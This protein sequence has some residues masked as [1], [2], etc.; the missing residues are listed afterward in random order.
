MYEQ[1][2]FGK[3]NINP[4]LSDIDFI[5]KHAVFNPTMSIKKNSSGNPAIN[6]KFVNESGNITESVSFSKEEFDVVNG[7]MRAKGTPVEDFSDLVTWTLAGADPSAYR[8]GNV[9]Y[10]S[11]RIANIINLNGKTPFTIP[12]G[13]RPNKPV[14]VS[15]IAHNQG[16]T[17]KYGMG[18]ATLNTD[19]RFAINVVTTGDA[20]FFQVTFSYVCAPAPVAATFSHMNMDAVEQANVLSARMA[21]AAESMS[22]SN[23][24]D[25]I[26]VGKFETNK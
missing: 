2:K 1:A 15:F 24:S 11:Y 3:L 16:G 26:T 12:E 9:C 10:I 13:Y 21:Q 4:A 22:I 25:F 5:D 19:G 20:C 18:F 17:A 7:V 8:V 6:F 14:Y 23:D